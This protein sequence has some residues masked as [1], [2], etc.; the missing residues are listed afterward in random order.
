MFLLAGTNK[1]DTIYV[2][3]HVSLWNPNL[4]GAV[5]AQ[6]CMQIFP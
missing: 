6:T 4:T 3:Q 5:N 1:F 2:Q